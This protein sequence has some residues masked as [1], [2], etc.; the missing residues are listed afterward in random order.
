MPQSCWMRTIT[1]TQFGASV[2]A[3]K[4]Q[5]RRIAS[6][7][8]QLVIGRMCTNIGVVVTLTIGSRASIFLNRSAYLPVRPRVARLCAGFGS[9]NTPTRSSHR[10]SMLKSAT[11]LLPR[12]SCPL[13]PHPHRQLLRNRSHRQLRA[14]VSEDAA[15]GTRQIAATRP[16]TMA[17]RGATT[18]LQIARRVTGPS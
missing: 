4:A 15:H 8:T 18:P 14:V 16:G 11:A 3:M 6:R 5:K 9:A 12:R 13:E 2:Q 7:T 10:A 1:V 17:S